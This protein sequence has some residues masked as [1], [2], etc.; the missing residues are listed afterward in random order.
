MSTASSDQWAGFSRRAPNSG[1]VICSM[2]LGGCTQV[3]GWKGL[4][5]HYAQSILQPSSASTAHK[6]APSLETEMFSLGIGLRAQELIW[7]ID[8]CHTPRSRWE[9][10][11]S[12]AQSDLGM[13]VGTAVLMLLLCPCPNQ[14]LFPHRFSARNPP[15]LAGFS[16]QEVVGCTQTSTPALHVHCSQLGCS[17]TASAGKLM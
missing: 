9:P 12:A 11:I 5:S 16:L 14:P 4:G 13:E 17:G 3:K 6:A 2:R 10:T 7:P 1:F 8:C 15:L